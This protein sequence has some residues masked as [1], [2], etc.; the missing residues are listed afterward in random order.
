MSTDESAAAASLLGLFS[1]PS[2]LPAPQPSAAATTH[3]PPRAMPMQLPAPSANRSSTMLPNHLSHP[4]LPV[5][6][7]G[8]VVLRKDAWW[9]FLMGTHPRSA[10][11]LRHFPGA[12]LA[13]VWSHFA[14]PTGVELE[15]T[16]HSVHR[17]RGPGDY[18]VS[19]LRKFE[20]ETILC[21]RST[22][23]PAEHALMLRASVRSECG[24]PLAA[25]A[26]DGAECCL[27]GDVVAPLVDGVAL[28]REL[29]MGRLLLSARHAGQRFRILVCPRDDAVARAH[30]HL[31]VL[32]EPFRVVTKLP[33]PPPL[34][35]PQ[36]PLAHE[37]LAPTAHAH[38]PQHA[39]QAAPQH[40]PPGHALT[41]AAHALPHGAPPAQLVPHASAP[42]PFHSGFVTSVAPLAQ[43]A[44]PPAHAPLHA[45]LHA[46]PHA[47]PPQPHMYAPY[48]P[49]SNAEQPL[50]QQYATAQAPP[51]QAPPA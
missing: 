42:F 39:P 23:R 33:P 26:D 11:P 50:P 35:A 47:A 3:P 14:A 20:L 41:P 31:A 9:A 6:I 49:H 18:V 51:A 12:V 29:K 36:P 7:N 38:A 43:Y 16:K 17:V 1:A 5:D 30:P 45:P 19:N 32:S 48:A 44:P 15:I 24:A 40:A 46:P 22:R 10:S 4:H 34:N 21:Y 37:R 13:C 2:S 25:G 8:V 28:F 27:Q